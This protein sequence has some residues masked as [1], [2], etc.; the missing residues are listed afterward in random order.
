MNARVGL[1][2]AL[3]LSML[4]YF[5]AEARPARSTAD[6]PIKVFADGTTRLVRAFA[7]MRVTV[8]IKGHSLPVDHA[9][10]FDRPGDVR[11]TGS[12]NPCMLV[13]ALTIRVNGQ[14]VDVPRSIPIRL[15]DVNRARLSVAGADTYKLA[16]EY[17]DAAEAY[18]AIIRF[19]RKRVNQL[20]IVDSEAGILAERTIYRDL[21]HAFDN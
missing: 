9:R 8:E 21:S 19:D 4:T 2:I 20:D 14:A 13:D 17:G 18:T 12:R 15:S 1:G 6:K 3:A 11:C 7:N 16:I 10:T 5:G